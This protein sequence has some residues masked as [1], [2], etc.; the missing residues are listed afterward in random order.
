MDDIKQEFAV[1]L[2]TSMV[3]DVQR[4]RQQP[5]EEK[6]WK[7][8]PT[9]VRAVIFVQALL[10]RRAFLLNFGGSY[11]DPDPDLLELAPPD[12]LMAVALYF[13]RRARNPSFVDYE[14]EALAVAGII[15]Q[16]E[17]GL[18]MSDVSD[19]AFYYKGTVPDG[20]MSLTILQE[21]LDSMVIK[22]QEELQDEIRLMEDPTPA[23]VH[24]T[25]EH[26][27]AS[28]HVPEEQAH[29]VFAES[30]LRLAE[31]CEEAAAEF[32]RE[33]D[34]AAT[35]PE[36]D[37]V[38]SRVEQSYGPVETPIREEV[39]VERRRRIQYLEMELETRW[40]RPFAGPLPPHSRAARR[41]ELELGKD[42][43]KVREFVQEERRYVAALEAQFEVKLAQYQAQLRELAAK[44]RDARARSIIADLDEQTDAVNRNVQ[45]TIEEA[46][47]QIGCDNAKVTQRAKEML[48]RDAHSTAYSIQAERVAEE[49][50]IEIAQNDPSPEAGD[51]R[52]GAALD[53]EALLDRLN[54]LHPV[55][56][57]LRDEFAAELDD[58]IAAREAAVATGAADEDEVGRPPSASARALPAGAA[59][60]EAAARP[61]S[62]AATESEPEGEDP[63]GA[64][65]GYA[66]LEHKEPEIT[67]PGRQGKLPN[68]GLPDIPTESEAKPVEFDPFDMDE[69]TK[70]LLDTFI[71]TT[72]AVPQEL[73]KDLT[74]VLTLEDAT[75]Q[76]VQQQT[77][78]VFKIKL[79]RALAEA[80]QVPRQRL[81]TLSLA[82]GSVK[83][84]LVIFEASEMEA[85]EAEPGSPP[86]TA[87]Q[88]Y[89]ALLEQLEDASSHL[90]LGELGPF[91][92]SASM[93][94]GVP[95]GAGA[96]GGRM[97]H[98][99]VAGAYSAHPLG[100]VS[101]DLPASNAMNRSF[102]NISSID[103][104]ASH[105]VSHV[106]AKAASTLRSAWGV[107]RL[108]PGS[109][110]AQQAFR[111]T[112]PKAEE[113]GTTELWAVPYD[114][115][116]MYTFYNKEKEAEAKEPKKL[117]KH[118]QKFTA[119]ATFHITR[120][121]VGGLPAAAAA[122]APAASGV[123]PH[124]AA[125]S[126]LPADGGAKPPTV[127]PGSLT[128]PA[129]DGSSTRDLE[130]DTAVTPQAKKKSGK[131]K[132][133]DGDVMATTGMSDTAESVGDLSPKSMTRQSSVGQFSEAPSSTKAKRRGKKK[134]AVT[135]E[136]E[137]PEPEIQAPSGTSGDE[138]STKGDTM[139]KTRSRRG[140]K[141]ADASASELSESAREDG[142]DSPSKDRTKAPRVPKGAL[143]VVVE[144]D[145]GGKAQPPSDEESS[146]SPDSHADARKA[147][148]AKRQ[149]KLQ[150]KKQA[151]SKSPDAA[152]KS[153]RSA[154]KEARQSPKDQGHS[155][156]AD[157][158]GK[159]LFP[160][161]HCWAGMYGGMP[162]TG[163]RRLHESHGR[164]PDL[165]DKNSTAD[166]MKTPAYVRQAYRHGTV[167]VGP[168]YRVSEE[169]LE[170]S[171]Q[172][173]AYEMLNA[174]I[175]KNDWK[176]SYSAVTKM[177]LGKL[178][179][180]EGIRAFRSQSLP[181]FS[182]TQQPPVSRR[183][184]HQPRPPPK[185]EAN[186]PDDFPPEDVGVAWP[187]EDARGGFRNASQLQAGDGGA[188]ATAA[189]QDLGGGDGMAR[190]KTE[191]VKVTVNRKEREKKKKKEPKQVD[192]SGGEGKKLSKKERKEKRRKEKEKEQGGKV[193][194]EGAD[195]TEAQEEA[196]REKGEKGKKRDKKKKK[197]DAEQ[198]PEEQRDEGQERPPE[199]TDAPAEEVAPQ[200]SDA[201]DAEMGVA[202]AGVAAETVFARK[203]S[204]GTW[205]APRPT[206]EGAHVVGLAMG[207]AVADAIDIDDILSPVDRDYIDVRFPGLS[208]EDVDQAKFK[209]QLIGE[210]ERLGV[211]QE[212]LATLTIELRAGSI[213]AR[214]FGPAA[215]LAEIRSKAFPGLEMF[216]SKAEELSPPA[217][218]AGEPEAAP[219]AVAWELPGLTV[220]PRS[221][222][223]G[224][225]ASRASGGASAAH[226]RR[227]GS[228]L[229]T[230]SIVEEPESPV[231]RIRAR[232][233]IGDVSPTSQRTSLR[234][235]SRPE[236]RGSGATV[237]V[238]S[239]CSMASEA[240]IDAAMEA[241]IT[242]VFDRVAEA[243]GQQE[244]DD[245][246]STAVLLE[247]DVPMSAV[248]SAMMMALRARPDDVREM[249]DAAT[250]TTALVKTVSPPS[251]TP[252]APS[253]VAAP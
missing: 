63:W 133:K 69:N 126:W 107:S 54:P 108:D 86:M 111:T 12:P 138:R 246:A 57:A 42:D 188:E 94:E 171:P 144:A 206:E 49:L 75:M 242:G 128:M 116:P 47:V 120:H 190:D 223:S 22:T 14:R 96:V 199:S 32:R 245:A 174:S 151:A 97:E 172:W 127:S 187:E 142:D 216:G 225:A 99:S 179:P 156:S 139:G 74:M 165:V 130:I 193:A 182:Q 11:K 112:C 48:S 121:P 80:V 176:R 178:G 250:Q 43:P 15:S 132:R 232:D 123:G 68:G 88:I 58:V 4:H 241:A 202:S 18:R 152:K 117:P 129:R 6:R 184:R 214:F 247:P 203:P 113:D 160:E 233:I 5:K 185:E 148:L 210:L 60:E 91:L 211:S 35:V 104:G 66:M 89:K 137:E 222:A 46:I 239:V 21:K 234:A 168:P 93:E 20:H 2:A 36:L 192:E 78:E 166:P 161:A 140:K 189:A 221:A 227:R 31:T 194:E 157:E 100:S 207:A 213:I 141:S 158:G 106:T 198:E 28:A 33:I 23:K 13:C 40:S 228:G 149:E 81:K 208:F 180:S 61:V 243:V 215:S 218:E 209:A 52:R 155:L 34:R 105:D 169:N 102:G 118:K 65:K 41:Y 90:R 143:K 231:H 162:G 201:M 39:E 197:G 150:Q 252:K 110:Q 17:V 226:A 173:S 196:D 87:A 248:P 95:G 71:G 37:A 154:E 145:G 146:G 7:M 163:T 30:K 167:G 135:V 238:V 25:I 183:R 29:R 170:K 159:A 3:E 153:K 9:V 82:P 103:L 56:N 70:H 230:P 177:R 115:Q 19:I 253:S 217:K 44:R 147:L 67:I 1:A 125:A 59:D 55:Q 114:K 45:Q 10:R 164:L 191:K 200:A 251:S 8:P 122:G 134:Q 124:M 240:E 119:H 84:T 131:K 101:R 205:L 64:P 224:G 76:L 244:E 98:G 220:S 77:E 73:P 237:T 204:V 83:A 79:A 27:R 26:H 235:L 24:A 229:S 212:A 72:N 38:R 53:L 62:P 92:G 85:A 181:Q 195:G 186:D 16:R 51:R 175:G 219:A 109:S 249:R 50:R 136:A 236:S